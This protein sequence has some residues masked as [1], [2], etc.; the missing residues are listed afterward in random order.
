MSKYL[1]IN[2]KVQYTGVRPKVQPTVVAVSAKKA[3]C[4]T[5]CIS[6]DDGKTWVKD[7]LNLILIQQSFKLGE[8][9]V[10]IQK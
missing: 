2:S 8:T 6:I 9:F 5:N 4:E 1:E 7:N 3:A 10:K